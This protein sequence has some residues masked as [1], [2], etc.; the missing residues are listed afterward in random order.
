MIEKDLR[1]VL[2]CLAEIDRRGGEEKRRNRSAHATD[3][4]TYNLVK[5]LF[6]AALNFYGKCFSKCEGRPVGLKCAQLDMRFREL[7]DT[8][9]AYRHNFA[10]HSGAKKLE[11]FE[12]ALVYPITYKKQVPFDIFMELNQ[13]DVFWPSIGEVSLSE[14]VEH[15]QAIT[16]AKIH[17]LI[18]KIREE[19]VM[20]KSSTYWPPK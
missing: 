10:A 20:A 13:P 15:V 9:I 11:Q 19:E 16:H 3:R 17:T 2:V 7:H 5:G 6:V 14:L 1:S 18:E 12:I 8:C 4:E